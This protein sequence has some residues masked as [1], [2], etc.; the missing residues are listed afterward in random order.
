MGI[1]GGTRFGGQ[2]ADGAAVTR[3]T[4][5]TTSGMAG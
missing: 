5:A 4:A 3:I 2:S 1:G